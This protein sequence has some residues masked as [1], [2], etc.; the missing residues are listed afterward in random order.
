MEFPPSLQS[1]ATVGRWLLLAPAVVAFAATLL[2]E[3]KFPHWPVR[4]WDFP[5]AQIGVVALATAALGALAALVVGRSALDYIVVALALLAALRQAMWI[6]PYTPLACNDLQLSS[7][8]GDRVFRLVISNVLQQN[9]QRDRWAEVI[10]AAD[11]D[12]IVC[13]ET[14]DRWT[15]A[16]DRALAGTHPHVVRHPQPNMYGIGVWSRLELRAVEVRYAV[17]RDVPS[18]HADLIL[19]DGAAVA[20]HC[21]HPH[22]PAPQENDSSAPR[23]AEL[24]LLARAIERAPARPT[25]VVGDLNDVAWSRTTELFLRLSGLLDPR[26]GRGLFNSFHADHALVRFPLDHVFVSPHFRLVEMRRLAHVGSDHFPMC[27]TL[28]LEPDAVNEQEP[29]ARDAGDEQEASERIEEQADR[30]R[31]GEEEGHVSEKTS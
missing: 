7:A 10:K 2:A 8:T 29:H 28:S 17:Q 15:N 21:L 24:V 6:W 23:D 19:K 13:A 9:E 30:E 26:R 12:V 3:T 31:S 11:A 16:I 14:D 1:V 25:L 18:V 20:L 27:I 4:M 22:P 5:R